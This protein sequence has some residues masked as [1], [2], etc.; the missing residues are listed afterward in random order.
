MDK[1][2]MKAYRGYDPGDD[3]NLYIHVDWTTIK[4]WN[5]KEALESIEA[6]QKE[7]WSNFEYMNDGKHTGNLHHFVHC[8]HK[9]D[10]IKNFYSN[11]LIGYYNFQNP[12]ITPYFANIFTKDQLEGYLRD[13]SP[14]PFM[15]DVHVKI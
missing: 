11:Y 12:Y 13:I 2:L 8:A 10:L 5:L 3:N 14:N 4:H 7:F 15:L 6:T 9:M 1:A